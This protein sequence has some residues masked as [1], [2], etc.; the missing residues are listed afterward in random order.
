MVGGLRELG[1]GVPVTPQGAFY[2]YAGCERLADDSSELVGRLLNEAGV[3]VVPGDDF[4]AFAAQR[5]VRFSYTASLDQL[6]EALRRLDVF[7][8][9]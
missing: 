3:A 8:N 2:V 7:V 9:R 5:H 6:H 4:G 1:F